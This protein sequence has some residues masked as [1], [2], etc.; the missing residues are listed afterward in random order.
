MMPPG[1]YSVPS[2]QSLIPQTPENHKGAHHCLTIPCHRCDSSLG[3]K[4]LTAALPLR[5]DRRK[6]TF[7]VSVIRNANEYVLRMVRNP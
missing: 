5:S 7:E 6:P 4:R 2:L 3:L 1:E